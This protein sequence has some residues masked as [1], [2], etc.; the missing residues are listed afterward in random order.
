MTKTR[1]PE[2]K[3]KPFFE[4]PEDVP[5]IGF[6]KGDFGKAFL[7]EYNGI[8]KADYK[9]VS[10]LNVLRYADIEN[11]VKHSTPFVVVLA[12]KILRREGLR[13]ATQADIE[14]AIRSGVLYLGVISDL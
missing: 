6:L 1:L 4:I 11:V 8:V 9:N 13:T 2:F 3:G 10:A 14:K 7:K 12:N 5:R